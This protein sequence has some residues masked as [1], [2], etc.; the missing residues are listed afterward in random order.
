MAELAGAHALVTQPTPPP[1]FHLD[2]VLLRRLSTARPLHPSLGFDMAAHA[3]EAAMHRR[4]PPCTLRAH[5]GGPPDQAVAP[6]AF[7]GHDY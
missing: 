4:H 2:L 7:V 6:D 3:S 1:F 5:S